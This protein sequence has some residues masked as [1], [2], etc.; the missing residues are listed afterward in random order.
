MFIYYETLPNDIRETFGWKIANYQELFF[1][2]YKRRFFMKFLL[3]GTELVALI[4]AVYFII[5]VLGGNNGWQAC[6]DRW[7]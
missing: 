1:R 4:M 5:F 3:S 6:I 2:S 7:T